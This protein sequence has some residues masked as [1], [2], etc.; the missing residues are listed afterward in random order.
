[1]V[2][3]TGG[4]TETQGEA[5]VWKLADPI[6][7]CRL[8]F[9]PGMNPESLEPWSV[10]YAVNNLDPPVITW[11]MAT[12]LAP[13]CTNYTSRACRTPYVF[14]QPCP[15]LTDEHGDFNFLA[16]VGGD[17][18]TYGRDIS[19]LTTQDDA[20]VVGF[21]GLPPLPLCGVACDL[22]AD[23]IS[24]P[25][26]SSVDALDRIS[27][28]GHE[29]RGVTNDGQIVGRGLDSENPSE[30]PWR[31]LYWADADSAPTPL[32]NWMP[33]DQEEDFSRA[34]AITPNA[35]P[36]E[37]VGWNE[38][39][40]LALLWRP[41]AAPDWEVV[42][43]DDEIGSCTGALSVRFAHDI[44]D[45]GWIVCLADYD[46][47]GGPDYHAVLLTPVE[48]CRW[49][50]A[51]ENQGPP[52]G[53]V[54]VNDFLEILAQW[55]PCPPAQFCT[56]DY[57]CSGDVGVTDFLEFLAHFGPCEGQGQQAAGAPGGPDGV[58]ALYEFL[59]A[60]GVDDPMIVELLVCA[61]YP[62]AC[63]E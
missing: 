38:S 43:L 27:A 56:A 14:D 4:F 60:A 35:A 49:D 21:S 22:T 34:E 18:S 57:D 59:A 11:D 46:P 3:Q 24:W 5:I 26:D 58:Q 63:K 6:P 39:K 54:G 52:D 53:T 61:A 28:D 31:A 51:G 40:S 55:G 42:L 7:T 48:T 13:N 36:P 19:N 50:I 9:A 20:Q 62:E 29:A 47:D 30:C 12:N 2:G 23:A 44:N 10:A 15:I 33:P 17:N 32:D 1:V 41:A 8:G 37:V 45:A 25:P 16:P